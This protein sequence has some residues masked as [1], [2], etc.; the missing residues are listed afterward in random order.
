MRKTLCALLCFGILDAQSDLESYFKHLMKRGPDIEFSKLDNPFLNPHVEQIYNLKI[1]A[2]FPGRVR[3]NGI[4][5]K[6]GDRIAQVRIQTIQARQLLLEYDE[7]LFP[8][9]LKSND[10]IYID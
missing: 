9:K 1:Q 10:K 3:I 6:E 2:I 8:L 4:W 7:V 5:Y